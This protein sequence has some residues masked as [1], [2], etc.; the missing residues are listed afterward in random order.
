[1]ERKGDGPVYYGRVLDGKCCHV[2]NRGN[3]RRAVFLKSGDY[4]SF[5]KAVANLSGNQRMLQ[6]L[7]LRRPH[8]PRLPCGVPGAACGSVA[9]ASGSSGGFRNTGVRAGCVSDGP[10]ALVYHAKFRVGR[11][12]WVLRCVER[13]PVPTAPANAEFTPEANVEMFRPASSHSFYSSTPGCGTAGR[14]NPSAP[15]RKKSVRRR[16][17]PYRTWLNRSVS[18]FSAPM[19]QRLT[20]LSMSWCKRCVVA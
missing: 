10:I 17:C 5:L 8:R 19:T 16:S 12:H 6:S 18:A 3:D 15:S 11:M 1:M 20:S 7:S 14:T 4:V 2:L 13:N 9:D